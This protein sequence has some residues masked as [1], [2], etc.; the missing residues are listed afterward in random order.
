MRGTLF[1]LVLALVLAAVPGQA[2][3]PKKDLRTAQFMRW[4]ASG[5]V[6]NIM[7]NESSDDI[8]DIQATAKFTR[9]PEKDQTKIVSVLCQMVVDHQYARMCDVQTAGVMV[10]TVS[11]TE[12][13]ADISWED[14][15]LAEVRK[16]ALFGH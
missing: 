10:A 13:G 15:Y 6:S 5:L 2:D 12:E 14:W 7:H 9:L 3:P 16:R 4:R 1:A 11:V 8:A